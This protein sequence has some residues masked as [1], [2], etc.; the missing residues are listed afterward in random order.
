MCTLLSDVLFYLSIH[1]VI[2]TT[3]IIASVYVCTCW[4]KNVSVYVW[5]YVCMFVRLCVL[6]CLR[7][8]PPPPR[9]LWVCFR[10]DPPKVK[11]HPEFKLLYKCPMATKFGRK[12]PLPKCNAFLRLKVMQGW[13]GVNQRSNWSEC[14]MATKFCKKNPW[15]KCSA[16]MGNS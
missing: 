1:Y 3:K 16:L 12:N 15:P 7:D 4:D 9:V 8:D 10:S 13:V 5:D 14:P 2:Y 6:S 11:C